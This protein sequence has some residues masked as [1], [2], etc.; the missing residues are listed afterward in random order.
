MC[1]TV[2]LT[3]FD[4]EQLIIEEQIK[5]TLVSNLYTYVDHRYRSI[6]VL[7]QLRSIEA[8]ILY[9]IGKRITFA[10]ELQ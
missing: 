3:V 6:Y 1:S 8:V 9:L 2:K 10:V 7:V 5:A 4:I